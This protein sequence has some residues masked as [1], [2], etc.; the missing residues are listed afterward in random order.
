MPSAS[1]AHPP[2]QGTGSPRL[3][4]KYT[5]PHNR[6][7]CVDV[8]HY[9]ESSSSD[10]VLSHGQCRCLMRCWVSFCC[11]LLFS[12]STIPSLEWKSMGGWLTDWLTDSVLVLSV[13]GRSVGLYYYQLLL[14]WIMERP[15]ACRLRQLLLPFNASL[16]L[17]HP[18]HISK[19][20]V[21]IETKCQILPWL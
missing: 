4:R 13:V 20:W 15:F 9:N 10:N 1:F 11:V 21:T 19:D 7:T 8:V 6:R 17:L 14:L 18:V 12:L 2:T 5:W 16:T 3:K